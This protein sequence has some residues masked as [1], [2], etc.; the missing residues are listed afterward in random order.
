MALAPLSTRLQP[1]PLLPTIKLG[2][3][4]AGSPVGGLVHALGPCG[5]LQRPL[6]WGWE[7]LL[8]PPQPP[9]V[10]SIRGLRLYFPALEP[11]VTWSALLP[12]VC[13]DLSLSECGATG[14]YPPLCLPRSL[15]L[16][17]RPSRF[18]CARMW[19][20]RVC[21]W[22]DCLPCSS[23]TPP[24]SVPPGPRESSPPQCPSLPLLQ[25]WMNVSFLSTW[26]R[27]SLLFD[28]SVSSGCAWR[29]SVSTYA[30]I[31]VLSKANSNS[32]FQYILC[33]Y[34]CQGVKEAVLGRERKTLKQL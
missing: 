8:L 28:F 32:L 33:N 13:P 30:I 31:L 20:L 9:G 16:W 6:L 15:P 22:S 14:C 19:G 29:H 24:V 7:S 17:V 5:S 25:V 3:S 21:E 2:P 27:T 12:A 26:C 4:G 11:W 10:F 23:H 1:L 34:T 18:I